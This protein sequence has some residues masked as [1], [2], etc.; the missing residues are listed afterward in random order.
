MRLL[1]IPLVAVAL[2][3]SA[4]AFLHSIALAS[5]AAP[6]DDWALVQVGATSS[7]DGLEG[8]RVGVVDSGVDALH[9]SLRGRVLPGRDFVDGGP[10][11]YDPLGHGT[12]V[13]GIIAGSGVGVAKNAV[14]LPVRVL[15]AQ[16]EGTVRRLALGIRWAAE[17]E[18]RLINA[19]VATSGMAPPLARALDY[20]W[21]HRALVV[22]IAGNAGGPVQWPAGYPKAVA[23]GATSRSGKLAD[24]SSR[25]AGLDLVAPGVDVRTLA[26]GGGYTTASGTSVAAPFVTGALSLLLGQ[27][28][29]LTTTELTERL[30]RSAHDLGSP[31]ADLRYGAGL[32]DIAAALETH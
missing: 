29:D 12:Q 30:R 17:N 11:T 7:P 18:S 28:P 10:G 5:P 3:V 32:L 2:L 8:V 6:T 27:E 20:A 19:S 4:G 15:D 31:G 1:L 26:A 13:A 9:P 16:G 21:A 23:V 14:I 22:A 24:F 25:G